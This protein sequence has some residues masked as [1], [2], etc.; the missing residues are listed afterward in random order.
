MPSFFSYFI[1]PAAPLLVF[2]R[3]P[4]EKNVDL[5]ILS[6]IDFGSIWRAVSFFLHEIHFE[7]WVYWNL[8]TNVDTGM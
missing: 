4:P 5:S 3:N 8:M 1:K 6:N 7:F 2:S